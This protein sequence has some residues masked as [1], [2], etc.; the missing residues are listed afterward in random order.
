[1]GR[2]DQEWAVFWCSLLSPLRLGEIPENQR[3]RYFQELSQQ[4]RLLPNG[5]RRHIS[6]RTFRRQWKRLQTEGVPGLFRRRRSDR[7]RPR[8]KHAK[9]LARAT[10]LKKE[11]PYRSAKVINRILKKEFGRGVPR[12]TI[13]RHLRREGATRQKLGVSTKKVRC[14]WTREQTNALWVGDF[15][16]GPLVMHQGEVIKTHLSAW[17]DCHS[18]YV[19]DARYYTDENL[20]TLVDS[21]LRAWGQHGASRELYVDNAKIYLA[22]ALKLACAELNIRLL[23]RPVRDPPAGGLIERFFQTLQVQLEAEIRAS[24]ILDL[25][26]LNRVL[27]AW[28]EV[29]YHQELHSETGQSP[30]ERYQEGSRFTRHVDLPEVLTF[31][32]RRVSRTVHQDYS[33]VR[34]DTLFFAVDR[35][36][37][38][39]DVI[40]QYDPYSSMDEV[41]IYSPAGKYLGRGRRYQR[42]KGSHP[43]P[44]PKTNTEPITPH[45]LDALRQEHERSQ[46]RQ[47]ARGIDYHSA[48][49]RSVWPLTRFASKFARLLGR[50]GGVSG[51]STQEMEA[52]AAFHARHQRLNESLLRE[53]FEHAE[54][55]SIPQILFHFQLLL[56]ERNV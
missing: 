21:L 7:D 17:I 55:T 24:K 23:H 53:A 19:L 3:E 39:D 14:R 29:D 49:Q 45:Y 15:E 4:D 18:R 26:E 22:N 5:Q 37:R 41:Q 47:R 35:Q 12:S 50:K 30:Q 56:K 40:V 6:A 34:V 13:Y 52:L 32:H 54:S 2:N 1:M 38:G 28:L 25:H 11:Q 42:E 20:D 36:L 46:Q 43:E 51:L 8:K 10:Q 16:H 9:L 48:R 27:S 44:E 33:D 31:F